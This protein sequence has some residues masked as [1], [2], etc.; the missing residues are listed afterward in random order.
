MV[1]LVPYMSAQLAQASLSWEPITPG[2]DET[3]MDGW[4]RRVLIHPSINLSRDITR[5]P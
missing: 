3:D 5:Y 4:I 2:S 1:T